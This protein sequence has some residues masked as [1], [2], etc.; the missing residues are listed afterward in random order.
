MTLM[1]LETLR[2]KEEADRK[3]WELTTEVGGYTIAELR[4]VSD[5]V[6]CPENWKSPWSAFVPAAMVPVVLRAAEFFHGGKPQVGGIEAITGRV[7]V[8]GRGYQG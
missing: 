2:T 4:R 1:T 5:L 6:F 8:S 3:A 7:L